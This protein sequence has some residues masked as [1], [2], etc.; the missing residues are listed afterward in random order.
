[1]GGPEGE[2][3]NQSVLDNRERPGSEGRGLAFA[4]MLDNII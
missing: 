2:T 3:W 4:P 1:M